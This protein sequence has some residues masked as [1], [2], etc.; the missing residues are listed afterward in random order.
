MDPLSLLLAA[1]LL[2]TNPT[3]PAP[4]TAIGPPA[5]FLGIQDEAEP[6]AEVGVEEE[7]PWA[8]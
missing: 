5:L 7:S 6:D 2:A 8:G 1:P 3:P 4:T